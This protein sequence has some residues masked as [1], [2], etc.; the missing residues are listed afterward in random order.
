MVLDAAAKVRE[1]DRKQRAAKTARLRKWA[2][3]TSTSS[4]ATARAYLR[5][6]NSLGSAN[7]LLEAQDASTQDPKAIMDTKDGSWFGRW[8]RDNGSTGEIKRALS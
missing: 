4:A 6:A 3:D 7:G 1:T 2:L 8:Q 5:K